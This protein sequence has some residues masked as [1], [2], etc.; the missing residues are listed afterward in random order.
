MNKTLYLQPWRQLE[1]LRKKWVRIPFGT[2][3]SQ[4]NFYGDYRGSKPSPASVNIVLDS[5]SSKEKY[6]SNVE[7]PYENEGNF[8]T[9]MDYVISGSLSESK[10]LV[11]RFIQRHSALKFVKLLSEE[12]FLKLSHLQ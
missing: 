10:F 5:N 6:I 12:Q 2:D 7:I 4:F 1:C 9:T 8:Y 11:E 3:V